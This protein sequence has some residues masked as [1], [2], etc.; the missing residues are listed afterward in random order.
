M[1]RPAGLLQPLEVPA[2][3]WADI[4]MDFVEGL[5]KV[6]EKSII[7]TVVDRFSKYAHFIALSHPY[8]ASSV[9]RAFFDGIVRLHG[10]PTSIVS[11]R[12]PSS[13]ATCG[14]TYSRWLASSSA[15]ARCSI[16]RRTARRR[17]STRCWPCTC[18]APRETAREPGWTGSRG[19]STATTPHTT[20]RFGRRRSRWSTGGPRRRFYH[21]AGAAQTDAADTLLRDS[22][23]ADVRERLLQARQHAK[24]YYDVHHREL[25]FA[26]GDWVWLRLVHRPTHSLERHPKGK[27]GPCYAGLF[28]V[29]EHIGQVAY[30]MQLPE[31]SRLHNVFQVGLLKPFH[32]DPPAS[33]PPMPPVHDGRVVVTPARV[34]RARLCQGVRDI[35]VEW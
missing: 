1:Q 5:P 7:L 12:D 11:D 29:I 35:L 20:R 18:G 24:H 34:R 13:R 26:V 2:Q 8:T 9:A 10:F 25:E 15:S 27:L 21:T 28:Q 4:S 31:G 33:T 17:S 14:A 16:L 23:L 30:R 3:V 22:F 6:G 32:G 19:R